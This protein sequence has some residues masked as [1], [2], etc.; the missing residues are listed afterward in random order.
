MRAR[1]WC[2]LWVCW[3]V[4]G[5]MAC[6]QQEAFRVERGLVKLGELGFVPVETPPQ[7]K[8]WLKR[9]L[10]AGQ[11]GASDVLHVYL[12]G[13]GAAWWAQKL[14]PTDPTPRF[15]VALPLAQMDHHPAVAYLA[16]PCQFVSAMARQD[17][18]VQWWTT[19]R[20]GDASVSI[21]AQALDT[22][23]QASGAR[24]LVLVGHSGGGTL[25]L[26]VAARRQDVRCVVTIASPLDVHAWTQGL[27][28]TP[29][30]DSL[31]PA[32]LPVPTGGFEE[33]HL[34]GEADRV[35]PAFAMGR[36]RARLRTDQV[37]T[38]AN[39]GHSQGWVQRWRQAQEAQTPM[40]S[41]LKDCLGS[42]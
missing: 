32:D 27:G 29:L 42:S 36:Y 6:A 22:V 10:P 9:P 41:W 3:V 19:A 4:F 20:W 18:P 12:E 11:A 34:R 1:A 25:A 5:L 21:T 16:R 7:I 2:W 13:D 37:M 26:L 30:T 17:C 39:Q 15:S 23:H 33:R 31:N 35:V 24:E 40:T 8:A 38:I 28:M 14:P